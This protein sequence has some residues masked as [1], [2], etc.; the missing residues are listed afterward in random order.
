MN[1]KNGDQK[2]ESINSR[3]NIMSLQDVLWRI[4]SHSGLH[5]LIL[6]CFRRHIPFSFTLIMEAVCSTEAPVPVDQITARHFSRTHDVRSHYC[7]DFQSIS[8]NPLNAEL[9]PICHLLALLG[10]ATIVV[11]S[12]LWVNMQLREFLNK[13][14]VL[15]VFCTVPINSLNANLNPICHLLAL[16]G[17]HLILHV[18]RIR[19]NIITQYKPTKSTFSKLIY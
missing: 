19:V 16:L 3:I 13:L 18:S 15:R 2:R 4:L 8:I 7:R 5:L 11:V 12:R 14:K 9:N 10:G 6:L 1:I 17:A